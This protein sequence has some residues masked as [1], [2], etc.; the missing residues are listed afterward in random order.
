MLRAMEIRDPIH[1]SME[2]IPPEVSVVD[3]AAYQRLRSIKQLGFS[4]FSFPGA[5]HNRYLHS[6]G[7]C[8]L[9]GKAFDSI[10]KGYQFEKPENRWRLRQ[11]LRLG[12]LLHD[13]G[14]GPLSHATEEVM[15]ALSELK[16]GVY[17][18]K[19]ALN[20]VSPKRTQ[21][22]HEDY[23]IKFITD[24][25]LTEVLQ[26][27]FQDISPTH[28][29]CLVDKELACP[30]DFFIDNG[31][32]LRTILSQLV[33]S[34]MDV[35]RMDYLVRDAYF[36]GTSYGAVET[37]WLLQNLTYHIVNGCMHLALNRRALYT[38]DDFLIS[39]HHMHLMVYYHHKSV[40]YEEL[41]LRYL[42]SSEC[43]FRLPADIGEYLKF[44]DSYLYE[45]LG[46]VENKW[47]RRIAQRRPFRMVFEHHVISQSGRVNGMKDFLSENN[48]ES[49]PTSSKTRLSKYHGDSLQDQAFSI[50][51]VDQYDKKARPVSIEECTKIFKHY[52]EARIIERLYVSPE[53]FS[54]AEQLI[55]DKSL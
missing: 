51:V 41:L 18:H 2:L 38:F 19:K 42:T 14:H 52:E 25:Q 10:F 13:I 15:P 49:I 16:I 23:T 21:A 3:S 11:V 12:A 30:D 29:A 20:P 34:E 37:G 48:I 26:R 45:H 31:V 27:S 22:D 33:S 55:T 50:Y 9:A 6:L 44:T 46:Q 7:V 53:N 54:K 39:R 35:D 24:S 28:V 32:D 36:C 47:A 4:E 17:A 1:G 43:T 5:T 40:I 8:H